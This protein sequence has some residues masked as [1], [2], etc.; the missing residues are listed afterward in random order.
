MRNFKK[1]AAIIVAV[2][3]LVTTGVLVFAD[4]FKSSL[5]IV[6][7]ITGKSAEDIT[8]DRAAGKTYGAIAKDSGKL[9]EFKAQMLEQRKALLDL[10]VK[11]GTI[12]QERADALYNAM[13]SNQAICNG[14]GNSG[15]GMKNG[16]GCASGS[17]GMGNGQG[18]GAG[19]GMGGGMGA[20]R[21]SNR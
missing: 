8:K 2:A 19:K 9:E 17:C 3:L 7:G 11:D 13:K 12:T 5:D 14:T 18:R 16:A 4:S 1:V 15:L 6:S 20:G 21:G 10:R